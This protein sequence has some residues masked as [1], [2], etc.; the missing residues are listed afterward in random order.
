[1]NNSQNSQFP[2]K[3][4]DEQVNPYPKKGRNNEILLNI[5][6]NHNFA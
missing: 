3:F 1:M 4:V 2:L 5:G 6:Q